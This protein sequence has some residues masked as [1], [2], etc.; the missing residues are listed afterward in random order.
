LVEVVVVVVVVVASTARDSVGVPDVAYVN[1]REANHTHR[2]K[3][4]WATVVSI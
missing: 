3:I 1:H 2:S 4:R